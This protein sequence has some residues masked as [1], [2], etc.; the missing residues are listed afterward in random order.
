[1]EMQ[2]FTIGQVAKR[3]SLSRSTLIY[4]DKI[5]VLSP[6]GRSES[7]YRLYSESDLEKMDR[8]M[9]FR[10]AGL[11]LDAISTLLGKEG[12]DLNSAFERRLTSINNEIQG[13][14]SQ[15]QVI[16][17]L[18]ENQ[19]SEKN[20]RILTKERWVAILKASGLDEEG[21][22]NWHIEFE[23]TSPEAH[24]DFLESIGIDDDEIGLIRDWSKTVGY[25]D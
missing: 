20:S 22:R 5:G 14:R 7:N 13:L 8:I 16:L 21:M 3:Y 9:L 2:M 10:S 1:M 19:T 4:Y 12:S 15:Q 23:K 18:L 17:K 24:Q 6:S 11:S 25:K